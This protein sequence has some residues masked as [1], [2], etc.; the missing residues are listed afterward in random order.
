MEYRDRTTSLMKKKEEMTLLKNRGTIKRNLFEQENDEEFKESKPEVFEEKKTLVRG[1]NQKRKNSEENDM[2]ER[3]YSGLED[4]SLMY[5]PQSMRS[6]ASFNERRHLDFNVKKM[7]ELIENCCTNPLKQVEYM[8]ELFKGVDFILNHED[9]WPDIFKCDV[10]SIASQSRLCKDMDY[11]LYN[12][13]ILI[14]NQEQLRGS[15]LGIIASMA[16]INHPP[17]ETFGFKC[18]KAVKELI[19]NDNPL[20]KNLVI[21]TLKNVIIP[22]IKKNELMKI[23]YN[24]INGVSLILANCFNKESSLFEPDLMVYAAIWI[25]EIKEIIEKIRELEDLQSYLKNYEVYCYHEV[26]LK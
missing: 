16:V 1:G 22:L 4:P 9:L 10:S 7:I 11:F 3:E 23:S 17:L 20:I 5:S 21:R 14:E 24:I 15:L 2:D 25:V 19:N 18:L 8:V 12:S 6:M 26:I 13:L